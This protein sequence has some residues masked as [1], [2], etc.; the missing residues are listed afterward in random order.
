MKLRIVTFLVSA[1]F[2]LSGCASTGTSTSVQ[3]SNGITTAATIGGDLLTD[4]L[5]G[6]AAVS[7]AETALSAAQQSMGGHGISVAN[8]GQYATAEQSAANTSGLTQAIATLTS[9]IQ[10][11]LAAGVSQSA[12]ESQVTQAQ[13]ALTTVVPAT[14]PS[15]PA[16]TAN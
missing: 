3:V 8:I 9:S 10:S 6:T 12:I 7:D 11:Q 1:V 15:A 13:T 4:V 14:I 5:E 2:G 16:T